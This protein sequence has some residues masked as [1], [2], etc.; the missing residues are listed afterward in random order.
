MR[1]RVKDTWHPE[2]N[3][4]TTPWVYSDHPNFEGNLESFF[5]WV[6]VHNDWK[7]DGVE[8]EHLLGGFDS[9]DY[10][11]ALRAIKEYSSSIDY[12]NLRR[13][14]S[15]SK[16]CEERLRLIKNETGCQDENFGSR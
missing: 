12:A 4:G 1:Y 10:A 2:I 3:K 8:T 9:S 14:E 11:A 6:A 15:F 7:L 5:D 13:V 16:W